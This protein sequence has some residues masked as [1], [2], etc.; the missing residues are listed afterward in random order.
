MPFHFLSCV[1]YFVSSNLLFFLL[2][3]SESRSVVSDSVTAMDHT[4]HGI[5]QAR[6]LEL[7]NSS[8]LQGLSPTPGSNPGLPHCKQILHQM[9]HQGSPRILEWVA[10]PFSSRFSPPRNRTEVSCIAGVFFTI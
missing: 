7:G 9:C 2:C 4:V 8:L 3:Q 10:Y 1:F 5:P 6:I